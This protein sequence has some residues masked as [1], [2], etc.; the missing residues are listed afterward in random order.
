MSINDVG[1]TQASYP[2]NS[3]NMPDYGNQQVQSQQVQPNNPTVNN[4]QD[5]GTQSGGH[6]ASVF[7]NLLDKLMQMAQSLIFAVPLVGSF[8]RSLTSNSGTS[9]GGQGIG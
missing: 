2:N 1:A 9:G 8:L 3:I 7:H 5:S 6:G 4:S